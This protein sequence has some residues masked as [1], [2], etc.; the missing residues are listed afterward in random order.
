[1]SYRAQ[2]RRAASLEEEEPECID[3]SPPRVFS[4]EFRRVVENVPS[5]SVDENV[6]QVWNEL[7]SLKS[8]LRKE[9]TEE[10]K[11][12]FAESQNAIIQTLRPVNRNDTE[13]IDLDQETTP[14]RIR[15]SLNKTLRFNDA[16]NLGPSC[17]RNI[18]FHG[19]HYLKAWPLSILFWKKTSIQSVKCF[20]RC[21][22]FYVR[23][24]RTS[25]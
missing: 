22:S 3:Q 21:R 1:M 10:I 17:S 15:S 16:E 4:T 12:L 24:S 7:E 20:E 2:K 18:L 19:I 23:Y 14:L 8:S 13:A 5:T 25:S 9:I 6:P 11:V